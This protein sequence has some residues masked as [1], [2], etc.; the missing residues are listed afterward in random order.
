M[1][2]VEKIKQNP[3]TELIKSRETIQDKPF[4]DLRHLNL[5]LSEPLSVRFSPD[6]AAVFRGA[7]STIEPSSPPLLGSHNL[8]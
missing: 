4:I 2:R 6:T 7:N 1:H 5:R 3:I 8:N